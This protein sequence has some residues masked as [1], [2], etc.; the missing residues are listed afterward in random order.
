[1]YS[2]CYII[3]KTAH[4]EGKH[5]EI[6]NLQKIRKAAGLSQSQLAKAAGVNVQVL[7]Q[8]EHGTRDINGAKLVTLLKLCN[9]LGCKLADIITD[10]ETQEQLES[11]GGR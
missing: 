5:M 2:K 10:R 6:T 3:E 11:Y 8:Y 4:T 1:M 9:V 7:Q